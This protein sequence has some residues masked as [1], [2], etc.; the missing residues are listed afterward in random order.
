MYSLPGG[1]V[2]EGESIV[3]ALDREIREETGYT[4]FEIQDCI[5]AFEYNYFS[6]ERGVNRKLTE[7]T[8]RVVLRSQEKKEPEL[9]D[10]EL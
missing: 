8:Y 1:G 3:E 9:T 2:E 4:D 10:R 5:G 7:Y 6:P